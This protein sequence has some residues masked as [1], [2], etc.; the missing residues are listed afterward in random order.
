M[1]VRID[2]PGIGIVEAEG[3][4]SEETLQRLAAALEKSSSGLTKEQKDQ[5]KATKDSTKAIKENTTGWVAAG[6]AFTQSLKNMALTATSVATK[7][8]ANYDAIAASP[9]KAGQ[10]L[11][12]TTIDIAADFT[13]GLVGAIP[14]IG[15]LAKAGVDAAAALT[16]LA[17]NVFAEQLEKNVEALREYA[18]TGIGFSGGMTQMQNVAQAAGLGIKD[19]AQGVTKVKSD[20]NLLGLAGGDAADRLAKNLGQLAKKG[21]G[22]LPSLREEIF[23]MGF[24][25]EQQIEV[26]ASYMANMQAAGKLEKMSKEDL[27]KGTRQYA[28]D[29]KVLADFTG[30]D[31]LKV[32]ERA[33]M[34]TMRA[35]IQQ[36]LDDTQQARYK[37]GIS[38]L[39]KLP[40]KSAEAQQALTQMVLTGTTNVEGF[41]MGPQRKMIE[42]MAKDIQSGTGSVIE[43][44]AGFMNQAQNEL[45]ADLAQG[46]MGLAKSLG[47]SG[48]AGAF[49]D[50]SDAILGMGKVSADQTKKGKDANEIMA[51]S[52]DKLATSIASVYDEAQ[53][54][55]V[56]LEGFVNSRLGDYSKILA[57]NFKRVT[58]TLTG[59]GGDVDP[60]TKKTAREKT[61]E[62][63]NPYVTGPDFGPTEE[64]LDEWVK[65]R[66]KFAGGGKLDA[67]KLG[68]AG[69]AGPELISGPSTI[70]SQASTEQL[71]VALD[72]MREMKGERL[73]RNDFEWNV[74]M[75]Q[76]RLAT[77]KDRTSAFG[78]LDIS[79]LESELSKRP[80]VEGP[81]AKAR[82][83]MME[84]EDQPTKWPGKEAADQT[85]ALLSE[86]VTAMK[87]NVSQTARV[88]MN[89]N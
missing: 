48:A 57:D 45:R 68:I 44:T 32:Q 13:G 3:I 30:K 49:S 38:V 11:L 18:K 22:G 25:Y 21:P 55:K 36:R 79:A 89:T 86:L 72:A 23:K 78:G 24:S 14:V 67:G 40:T 10:A 2:I 29:L 80:E 35:V 37:D 75:E 34:A 65:K 51:T 46:Q 74:V 53:K 64:E 52:M 5:A 39:E 12:N 88:A 82:A 60:V 59:A 70:L 43:N 73:G 61:R 54:F 66:K 47:V 26:A 62:R 87:Q 76:K 71:I 17:N 81:M 85:V 84:G 28:A 42:Q 33:R 15:G 4:A 1:A 6:D 31:A 41:T 77:L 58:D 19:F 9:I 63:A 16:K 69:E 83:A 50:T 27:A 56:Q 20:L 7:F 8:F